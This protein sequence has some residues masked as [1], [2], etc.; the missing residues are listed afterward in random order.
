MK[1]FTIKKLCIIIAIS[2]ILLFYYASW[3]RIAQMRS[4][5]LEHRRLH[6]HFQLDLSSYPK[7]NDRKTIKKLYCY[8]NL[9][10]VMIARCNRERMLEN[11]YYYYAMMPWLA[12]PPDPD[13]SDELRRLSIFYLEI[14]EFHDRAAQMLLDECKLVEN[15]RTNIDEITAEKIYYLKFRADIESIL[16][17]QFE[18]AAKFPHE[19][20]DSPTRFDEIIRECAMS[21]GFDAP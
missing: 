19:P 2:S 15:N 16:S 3:P 17:H 6:R 11:K 1:K 20:E 5:F 10:N 4:L 8:E 12:C 7:E 18:E 9:R 21:R 13:D 14:S